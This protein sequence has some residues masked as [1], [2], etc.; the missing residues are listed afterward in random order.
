MKIRMNEE[1]IIETID[2]LY[3]KYKVDKSFYSERHIN[4]KNIVVRKE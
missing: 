4:H 2:I 1:K 3:E